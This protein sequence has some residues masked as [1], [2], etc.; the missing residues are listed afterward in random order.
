MNWI[1]A[2]LF[3]VICRPGIIHEVDGTTTDLLSTGGPYNRYYYE[4]DYPP[5]AYLYTSYDRR[6]SVW[7]YVEDSCYYLYDSAKVNRNF[8]IQP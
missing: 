2:V 7:F 6:D 8:E 1:I 5:G 4:L 3:T